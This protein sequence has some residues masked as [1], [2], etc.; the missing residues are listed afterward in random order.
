MHWSCI[1][2]QHAKKRNEGAALSVDSSSLHFSLFCLLRITNCGMTS[3]TFNI[4]NFNAI[5]EEDRMLLGT[6]CNLLRCRVRRRRLRPSR[7]WRRPWTL[8]H[9]HRCIARAS[10]TRRWTRTRIQ[11]RRSPIRRR[12]R[13]TARAWSRRHRRC[14]CRVCFS[15]TVARSRRLLRLC[16]CTVR[17]WSCLRLRRL[18]P[19]HPRH[20][21]RRRPRRRPCLRCIVLTWRRRLLRPL[22]TSRRC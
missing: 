2:K 9:R 11:R 5:D 4:N 21:L 3:T 10:T 6:V 18:H 16:R 8:R 22:Q 1:F 14:R 19:R 15:L 12:C 7:P 20:P 17:M 13:C